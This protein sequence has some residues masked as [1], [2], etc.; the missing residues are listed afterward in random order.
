MWEIP[1]LKDILNLVLFLKYVHRRKESKGNQQIIRQ[2]MPQS[3]S[4]FPQV[5]PPVA[6]K[7]LLLMESLTRGAPRNPK[8]TGHRQDYG[9]LSTSCRVR[10]VAE[11][12]SPS[13]KLCN[14]QYPYFPLS[15]FFSALVLK[16]IFK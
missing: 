13:C 7:G 14:P 15:A 3:N 1:K 8:S 16:P 6:R 9:L 2:T 11:D 5:E 4:L 10:H 12:T